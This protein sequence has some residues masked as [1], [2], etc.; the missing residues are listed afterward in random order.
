MPQVSR[1]LRLVVRD[2]PL[3]SRPLAHAVPDR[4]AEVGR[5]PTTLDLE[6]LV[7][8]PRLVKPDRRTVRDLRERVFELVAV[9]EDL[10]GGKD[11]LER[12]RFQTSDATQCV[13]DLCLF[14][15]HLCVV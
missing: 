6:H 11:G 13:L 7:P 12:R 8:T 10:P 1:L 3:L 15:R 14:R 2:E 4:I 9:V 5:E